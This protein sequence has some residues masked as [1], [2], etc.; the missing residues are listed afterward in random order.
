[1]K[2]KL[3]VIFVFFFLMIRRPPRS[4][5]SRSS[6]ASDVYKRQ[7]QNLF[8]VGDGPEGGG[9]EIDIGPGQPVGTDPDLDVP[10]DRVPAGAA[11]RIQARVRPQELLPRR[12][13]VPVRRGAHRGKGG[14]LSRQPFRLGGRDLRAQ[15]RGD[16]VP[17]GKETAHSP[18][19][20]QGK[21][22]ETEEAEKEEPADRLPDEGTPGKTPVDPPQ[23][24]L[25]AQP[26]SP[27]TP[28]T[29]R[30]YTRKG[31][32]GSGSPAAKA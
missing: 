30:R 16:G 29:G 20:E 21:E 25:F 18:R 8:D 2:V 23:G 14:D 6:A 31:P 19:Q 15:H 4:T 32:T 9:D 10:G 26:G 12:L 7:H 13:R 24:R 27:F 3:G 22:R 11:Q 28:G 5:Q 17:V 1:M